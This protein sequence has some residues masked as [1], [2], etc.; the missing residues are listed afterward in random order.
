MSLVQTII[1][2]LRCLGFLLVLGISNDEFFVLLI[3]APM[4]KLKLAMLNA[5]IRQILNYVL[6]T[7]E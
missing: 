4:L 3:L 6:I 2:L 5:T 1:C 7:K